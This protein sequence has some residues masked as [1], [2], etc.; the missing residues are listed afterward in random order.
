VV[1]VAVAVAML[2]IVGVADGCLLIRYI[3][4]EVSPLT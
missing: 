4:S 1:S 2:V 3:N